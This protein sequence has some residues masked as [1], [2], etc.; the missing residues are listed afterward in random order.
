[1]SDRKP[2]RDD[3]HVNRQGDEPG[4]SDI[5]LLVGIVL[6]A[7][8]LI[9]PEEE[10]TL[11]IENTMKSFNNTAG[12]ESTEPQNDRISGLFRM[13]AGLDDGLHARM[14]RATVSDFAVRIFVA[15]VGL[16]LILTAKYTSRRPDA[17]C[18]LKTRLGLSFWLGTKA[19]DRDGGVCVV[20]LEGMLGVFGEQDVVECPPRD[21]RWQAPAVE[22]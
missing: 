17:A 18:R 13:A 8:A 4:V 14:V 16:A 3:A 19:R 11:R 22:Q 6:L 9:M 12:V 15:L 21:R 7:I 10:V 20:H 5:K 2:T 1:M